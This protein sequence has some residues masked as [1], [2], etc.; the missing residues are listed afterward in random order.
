MTEYYR[1]C[2][3]Y[4]TFPSPCSK[5][6]AVP[7][8][9]GQSRITITL[10]EELLESVDAARGG[11]SRSAFI[12]EA[13]VEKLD[14]DEKLSLAPDRVGVGGRPT[15][16]PKDAVPK[17]AVPKDA[18]PKDAEPKESGPKDAVPKNRPYSLAGAREEMVAEMPLTLPYLGAVAA[19]DPLAD[20]LHEEVPVRRLYSKG[21]YVVRVSGDSMEPE[22]S[23]GDFIVVDAR[24]AFTPAHGRVCVVSSGGGSSV[25]V[26]DRKRQVFRSLNPDF[27]D[28]EPSEEMVFQG[29]FVEKL[30]LE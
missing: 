10:S 27:P 3:F 22:L 17:D 9:K 16:K 14:L 6:E 30:D 2:K 1:V 11:M 26:W 12:R 23:D 24:E 20:D 13:M 29:Y 4:F 21:H 15:H 25:K 5:N 28:I 8:S 7:R 18:V 19:G